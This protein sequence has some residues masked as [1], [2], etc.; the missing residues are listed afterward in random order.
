[1]PTDLEL[2]QQIEQEIGTK[3]EKKDNIGSREII[4][5]AYEQNDSGQVIKIVL[6]RLNL[7]EIPKAVFELEHLVFLNLCDNQLTS[8]PKEIAQLTDLTE[9][10]LVNNQLTSL[11]KEIAQLTNLTTL[12]LTNS[13]LTSLPKEIT[14][15]KN[16]TRLYLGFSELSRFPKK[17]TQLKNLTKLY[18]HN[19]LL[20]SLPKEIAQ[21]TNLTTLTLGSNL[22]TTLPKEIAQLKNLTTLTLED[23][24][25]ESPPPEIIRRGIPAIFEY[26]NQSADTLVNE[27]KLILVGQG[28]VGKTCLA[29]Q[30]IHSTFHKHKT[31]EGIDI[32]K[33]TIN[34]PTDKKEEIKLNVWDFGGQE[35]YHS[36]HQFFLTKRSLYILVWNARKSKDYDH[37]DYWLHTI[38]AFSDNSPV[39]IVLAKC[40][41]RDDDLNLKDLRHK[42][43]NIVDLYKVDNKDGTGI[44]ELKDVIRTKSWTLDHMQTGW[45]TSWFNVRK[46]LEADERNWIEYREFKD[47]CKS[48]KLDQQQIDVLD[49][50]LHDL[51]VII[52]FRDRMDLRNMVILDAEWATSAVYKILDTS[53]IRTAG[54]ILIHDDL[55]T[56]W[57]PEKYPESIQAELLKLMERFEL[58]Y[59]LP[60]NIT[61]LIPELLPSTEPDYDW[62]SSDNLLFQYRYEFLPAGVIPR[63]IVNAHQTL[64]KNDNGELMQWREGAIIT[65]ENARAVVKGKRLEKNIEIT[66]SGA[67]GKKRELLAIIRNHFA[68]INSSV[69]NIKITQKIPCN[70]TPNCTKSYD[71]EDLLKGEQKGE[72]SIKCDK[73][74]EEVHLSKLLDGYE[75][76]DNRMKNIEERDKNEVDKRI[77]LTINQNVSQNNKQSQ[78]NTQKQSVKIDFDIK[79]ELPAIQSDFAELRESLEDVDPKLDKQLKEIEDCLDDVNADSKPEQFNKPMNKMQRFLKKVADEDSDIHKVIQNTKNGIESA[80]KVGKTY[81]KFAQWLPALPVIPDLFLG[82]SRLQ[83]EA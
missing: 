28:D 80:Q 74:W 62:D 42:F 41:E 83:A 65:I 52:H 24:P 77:N 49:D 78:E 66:I 35:I 21:L 13:Q 16:L 53:S 76:K 23:N 38:A 10:R 50:Y 79:I 19:N 58:S 8:L 26:L 9:L 54:G 30:L 44:P 64:E 81:N 69:T 68:H 1:M 29:E 4:L 25:L 37:I 60:D 22:L 82:E 63:F 15:L 7:T 18:L 14:Q 56:I 27:A 61:H 55:G 45:V 46:K 75:T 33:W 67:V 3:L 59:E 2:I 70:C 57:N 40:H 36:T 51:G 34:A 11:P 71:Y 72:T 5:G 43:P 47:I 6:V 39:L 12:N 31:T 20:T 32:T 17:I 48:E 73:N